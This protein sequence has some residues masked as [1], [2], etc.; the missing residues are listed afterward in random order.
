MTAMLFNILEK[1]QN[2]GFRYPFKRLAVCLLHLDG[3]A[4]FAFMDE[5][6][7]SNGTYSY[8]EELGGVDGDFPYSD[9]EQFFIAHNIQMYEIF[10]QTNENCYKTL[11]YGCLP[12]TEKYGRFF[13]IYRCLDLRG[14]CNVTIVEQNESFHNYIRFDMGQD[15]YVEA[16]DDVITNSREFWIGRA[17]SGQKFFVGG[18]SLDRQNKIKLFDEDGRFIIDGKIAEF[19]CALTIKQEYLY[20]D[21]DYNLSTLGLTIRGEQ[22]EDESD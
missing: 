4:S 15:Y 20:I 11:Q 6:D 8:F 19:L 16:Y 14:A 5:T 12:I 17:F 9:V 1:T 18:Y 21:N 7:V 13:D 3:T 2:E 22:L 10:Q